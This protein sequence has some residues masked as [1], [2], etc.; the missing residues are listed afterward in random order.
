MGGLTEWALRRWQDV[1][2]YGLLL[3]MCLVGSATPRAALADP[4]IGVDPDHL[5][6]VLAQGD[7]D[8]QNLTISNTGDA[9]LDWAVTETAPPGFQRIGAADLQPGEDLPR[10]AV[11]DPTGHF[12]YFGT[13]TA[14][15]K[16]VKVDLATFQRTGSLT[17]A[18]GQNRLVSAAIDPAG[19][20]AYFGT[21]TTP[22][23][24]VKVDLATLELVGAITLDAGEDQLVSA[25]IDP[26]GDFAYFGT[27]SSPGQ[28]VK[29][30]LATFTRVDVITLDAGEDEVLCAIM[31]P[32]GEFA[33]FG[34]NTSPGEVI[35]ID[36]ATFTRADTLM[37][38]PGED[39]VHAA[40][41]DATGSLAYFAV[42]TFPGVVVKVD[43]VAFARVGAA[44]FSDEE[45]GAQVALI[46]PAG[47]FG[48]FGLP[49]I[50]GQ[51]VKVDLAAMQR[52]DG[53]TLADDEDL[54][55]AGVMDP[56][57]AFA[58]FGASLYP[59]TLATKVVKVGLQAPDCTL[60]PWASVDPTSGSIAAGDNQIAGV[61]FDTTAQD[62][63]N[64]AATLCLGSN[65]PA[66]PLATI[67]LSLTVTEGSPAPVLSFGPS[68]LDFGDVQLTDT[69]APQ[70]AT[71]HNTGSA[72]ATSLDFGD[73]TGTGFNA[74]TSACGATLAVGESCVVSVTFAPIVLGAADAS[75]TVGSAQGASA[76]LGLSGNGI[77][78]V[79]P[80][81]IE[82]DPT[83]LA[84]TLAPGAT[85]TQNLTIA[86]VGV[87]ML[88]WAISEDSGFRRVGAVSPQHSEDTASAVIDP[89]GRYAYFGTWSNTGYVV[90][91]DL[92]TFQPAGFI[93]PADGEGG[94]VSGVIDPAGHYAYFGTYTDP[95]K[96][97]KIDLETFQ[98]AG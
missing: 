24:V 98:E 19:A 65:D 79:P 53:I 69:S 56:A 6:D 9:A 47:A 73:L 87:E 34:T 49:T 52:V 13:F 16:V 2:L 30:D 46:D 89:A 51:I 77:P 64:Y 45:Q 11:I 72:D 37:L 95:G 97:V 75:L 55:R 67:P 74:D 60:P 92:A 26:A 96:V 54:V 12:A 10:S 90:K 31:D 41:I 84:A 3:A 61:T 94:F 70:T 36:L 80:P 35:K 20:F 43:L 88:D 76:A 68:S 29:I 83:F 21:N 85:A 1:L 42:D 4:I 82:L 62:P 25:V 33:Y 27:S 8:L 32:A 78:T 22:G 40:A 18:A 17:L 59:G 86:N 5:S 81:A 28:I 71:L 48:Y 38:D 50:P 63:G 91:V 44:T 14:P 58:Y 15:G 66:R 93:T 23:Q 57:G 39:L 7:T